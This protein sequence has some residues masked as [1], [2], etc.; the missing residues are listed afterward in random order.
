MA[1]VN[2]KETTI[3]LP[4]QRGLERMATSPK[5]KRVSL[6]KLGQTLKIELKNDVVFMVPTRLIQI[7]NGANVD[8]IRVVE[9]LLDGMYLRWPRLDEDLKVQ[10]LLEGTFGTARWM[11]G[12]KEHLAEHGRKGGSRRSTAK[13]AAARI[14]GTKGGRPRKARSA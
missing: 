8:D 13:T 5:A 2:T 7:F 1:S 12:L 14:N 9:L 6:D 10:S 4:R 11:N 3:D